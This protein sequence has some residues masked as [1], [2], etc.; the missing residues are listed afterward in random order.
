MATDFQATFID[1]DTFTE[2]LQRAGLDGPSTVAGGGRQM[3][4]VDWFGTVVAVD[5]NGSVWRRHKLNHGTVA[6]PALSGNHLHVATT[7]GLH[8][9]TLDLQEVGFFP[10][11][12]AGFSSPAIG[13]DG[14]VYVA[15]GSIL[16]A[17]SDLLPS[18]GGGFR[19]L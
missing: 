12:G 4:F 8:T 11:D 16:F 6:F 18:I 10:L 15:A 19:N 2:Y 9:L 7:A 13:S 14:A 17:F 5:P 1:Q 3:Y